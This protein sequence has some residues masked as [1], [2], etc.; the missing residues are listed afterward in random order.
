[1]AKTHG[2]KQSRNSRID[3]LREECRR[4]KYMSTNSLA[5]RLVRKGMFDDEE[6]A[7]TRVRYAR[8]Q[9]GEKNRRGASEII[10]IESEIP[11]AEVERNDPYDLTIAGKGVVMSDLQIPYH[12]REAI[13]RAVDDAVQKEHTDF[14]ILNGDVL[15][16]YELSKFEKNKNR[17]SMDE[18]IAITKEML[19][20]LS[21]A[22]GKIIYKF[23][24]HEDRYRKFFWTQAPQLQGLRSSCLAS[25]LGLAD[26]D[27]DFVD[28]M[29]MIQVGKHLRIF[30]GHEFLSNLAK[31]TPAKSLMEKAGTCS[32]AG[33]IHK[34]DHYTRKNVDDVNQSSWTTG[35]L[36]GLKPQWMPYNQWQHGYALLEF[37]GSWWEFRPRRI[38]E[39][40]VV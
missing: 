33:H 32:V 25:E 28:H 27:I 18:E 8:G 36:C 35:C 5:K 31:N 10:Q 14:C 1:M 37:D 19:D 30:H 21:T 11:A 17:R 29:R 6:H 13:A 20:F 3:A 39:G 22:F 4:A 16:A 26:R 15:D 2:R 12:C 7:R 40:R 34:G 24:N 23:G 38:V 9:M